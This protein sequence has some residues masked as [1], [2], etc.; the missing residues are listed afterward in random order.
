MNAY[1]SF[2]EQALHYFVRP[3]AGMPDAAVASP[4]DWRGPQLA[5]RQDEWLVRLTA[6][7]IG[8]IGEAT[9]ALMARGVPMADVARDDFVLPTLAGT[10]RAWRDEIDHGRGFLLVRGLPVR[11]WGDDKCAYAYW[12]LG[13]HLG[14]P[15]AQNPQDELLGHVIDYGEKADNPVVRLYRTA[16][17]IDFHCDAAD[18]VGLLCLRTARSGGQS[19]IVSSVA[20]FNEVQRRRPDLASRLFEP[21]VLDRR[22]EERAG[23]PASVPIQPCCFGEDGRLRTFYHSEYFRSAARLQGI[24]IDERAR[25]LLDLYDQLCASPDFHLDMWLEPGDIQIISNHT[26]VHS[27]T[28]YE[29]WPE[30]DRKRHLLRL[31]L[32]L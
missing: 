31:W 2:A 10:I 25:E 4:A 28:A 19:R 1:R 27:R 6:R 20:V 9:D 26:T 24:S 11:D 30:P 29:D 21:F 17:K 23:E 14:T 13:H 16:G 22:G 15:G 3:H 18:A 12:G 32:S 8:E 5:A 7:E